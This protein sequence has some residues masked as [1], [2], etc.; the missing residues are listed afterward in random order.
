MPAKT[1]L[2]VLFVISLG[3]VVVLYLSAL[4]QGVNADTAAAKYEILAATNPLAPGTLLR[5]QDVVWQ[6]MASTAETGQIPRPPVAT[7]RAKPEVEEQARAEVY[8]AALRVGL[9]AGA[10]I[11]RGIIV[12][13]GDRD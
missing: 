11:W 4:S 7:R 6:P 9:A 3:V 10:P 13:P 8:G 12:K 5:A 2:T 1:I